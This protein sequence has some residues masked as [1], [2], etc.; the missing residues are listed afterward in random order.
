MKLE[1]V[2]I[3]KTKCLRHSQS[4]GQVINKIGYNMDKKVGHKEVNSMLKVRVSHR[5]FVI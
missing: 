1:K 2:E 4:D 3:L 5:S